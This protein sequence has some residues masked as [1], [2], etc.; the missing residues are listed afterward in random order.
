MNSFPIQPT[1][2]FPIL[3]QP[4]I[5]GIDNWKEPFA[6]SDC[7]AYI[8]WIAP[9]YISH[10]SLS[11]IFKEQR[12]RQL[13][14][15]TPLYLL[16]LHCTRCA[17]FVRSLKRGSLYMRI[18]DNYQISLLDEV[19]HLYVKFRKREEEEGLKRLSRN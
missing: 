5:H 8:Y 17:L 2:K 9:L 19:S 15:F 18:P 11:L 14:H 4:S 12:E 6:I 3:C 7:S 1:Q 16:C 10:I 13:A